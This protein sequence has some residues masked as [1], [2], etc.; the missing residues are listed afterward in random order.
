[1]R[2]PFGLGRRSSP[3]NGASGGSVDASSPT[4]SRSAAGGSGTVP[5]P[6][7]AWAS[8]PPIQRAAGS[9]PL[10]AAPAAFAG[11]LP[12]TQGLPPVIQELGHEVSPMAT[13]GLVVA[14]VRAVEQASAGSVPAPV[15]RR[16]R[17]GAQPRAASAQPEAFAA[18]E[19]E[20]PAMAVARA[21]SGS[22]PSSSSSSSPA[23]VVS[24]S[25]AD[26]DAGDDDAIGAS[27]VA[28]PETA[29]VRSLPTVSRS[30]IRVP[31]RP[32]T[33]AASV[34]RPVAQRSHAGHSHAGPTDGAQ[35]PAAALPAPSGGM[36]RA[37]SNP[38]LARSA[39]PTVSR[40]ASTSSDTTSGTNAAASEPAGS[41]L[42]VLAPGSS[43]R[44]VGEPTS[45][46]PTARPIGSAP[47]PVVS[48]STMAGPMPLAASGLRPTNQREGDGQ[49]EG[50]EDE[51]PVQRTAASASGS[52][53][54]SAP[55][56]PA[57][58]VLTVS[59][60]ARE[61]AGG[62]PAPAAAGAATSASG[63]SGTG[64]G[65]PLQRTS[66]TAIRPIAAHNPIRPAVTLQ[67]HADGDDGAGDDE[68]DAALPSP[69]WAP[70]ADR[71]SASPSPA[72]SA[73]LG[74]GPW[75]Q[76]SAFATPARAA[77]AGSPASAIRSAGDQA[78]ASPAVQRS[79]RTSGSAPRLPLAVA[80]TAPAAPA[81]SASVPGGVP[82]WSA[83]GTTVT[84]PA[85]SITG[86]SV[87]QTSRSGSPTYPA[88]S[89]TVQRD[90]TTTSPTPAAAGAGSPTAAAARVGHSE[91]ELDDLARQLFGRIRTRL[92]ADLLHDREAS[93]FTFDNV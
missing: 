80:P 17:S 34:V 78:W 13:P 55:A 47:S 11:S 2:L 50:V 15:Q 23:P 18:A 59:R 81:A 42:P 22:T 57:L 39:M 56:F 41:S 20:Q 32:L 91:R 87:V 40:Q 14:R 66:G 65:L 82:D 73:G 35:A 61:G 93:G 27:S 67:R 48:R 9:M 53:S 1:M 6:S 37:P 64:A 31:D 62:V 10:V 46:P 45:L 49:D 75:V 5:V 85:G 25:A 7:R 29:P 36:R 74:A 84:F 38:A 88:A 16:A 90:S 21:T 24:R 69:W 51:A 28:P 86:A 77:A 19:P 76:R 30:A 12:G 89:P 44:G 4:V 92:R 54:S 83:P 72:S 33:S 52:R 68:G 26:A 79:A 63:P 43:R 71:P 58:P 60:S 8:L 3:G 70:A